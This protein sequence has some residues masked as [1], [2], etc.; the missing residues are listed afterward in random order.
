MARASTNATSP[1]ERFFQ[2][3]VLGLVA[4]GYLAVAG[5]GVLDVPTTLLMVAA[6]GVRSLFSA[7]LIYYQIPVRVINLVT[8]AYM[9]FYAVDEMWI[10]R[11]LI[12]ATVHLVFF[13]AII[14]VL[15]AHTNRDYLLLK[16]IAFMELLA[17]CILSSNLN[18]FLFLA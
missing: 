10:S 7:G 3:S 11:S 5:S 12:P 15:T 18:F 1:V 6:L 13:L 4:S 17:A 2:F 9:V 16:L 8:L 14:K